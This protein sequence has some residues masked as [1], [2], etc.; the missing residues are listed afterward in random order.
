[1][2]SQSNSIKVTFAEARGRYELKC[3][4]SDRELARKAGFF[5]DTRDNLWVSF[6]AKSAYNL[7]ENC[8]EPTKLKVQS[9]LKIPVV[10][11]PAP[12]RLQFPE[13]MKPY[14]VQ[15][16]AVNWILSRKNSYIAYE[17]GLGKTAIAIM[18]SNSVNGLTV[19]VCPTFLKQNWVREIGLWSTKLSSVDDSFI[20]VVDS[21]KAVIDPRCEYV[22]VPYSVIATPAIFFQLSNLKIDMLILDEAHYV[23]N[24]QAHSSIAVYG[25]PIRSN[26]MPAGDTVETSIRHK[27]DGVFASAER[28]VCLSGTPLT[29]R[30]MDAFLPLSKLAPHTINFL[31]RHQYGV[32]YCNAIE[33]PYG[34]S[35]NGATHGEELYSRITKDFMIIKRIEDCVELPPVLPPKVIYLSTDGQK[36]AFKTT[37]VEM[38]A[39]LKLEDVFKYEAMVNEAFEAKKERA[40]AMIEATNKD[41]ALKT[42]MLLAE[43]RQTQGKAKAHLGAPVIEELLTDGPLVVFAYHKEVIRILEVALEKY[44]PLVLTGQTKDRQSIVDTFQ[45]SKDHN[46]IICQIKAAGV[47]LT[48]TKSATVV[49][50]EWSWQHAE[51]EQAASRCRRIGQ[52]KPFQRIYLAVENSIDNYIL[53]NNLTKDKN[54]S[55]VI[56]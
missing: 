18:A 29:N 10:K 17:Q 53:N 56:K 6:A 4:F 36:K 27:F 34:W 5:W 32:R 38:L 1:M 22:I 41:P 28:V 31:N 52:T 7:L 43:L 50:V 47:G 55:K 2:T 19:I 35:Y 49:F 23:K 8:D 45:T 14:P 11:T 40:E 16:E 37:G 9:D 44:K 54:I 15:L 21:R 13:N 48:L 51:N 12:S 33:T 26:K 30:Y 25:G 3:H 24:P 46:L 39:G 20:Q 42:F